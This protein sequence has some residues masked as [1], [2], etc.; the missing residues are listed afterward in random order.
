MFLA[1]CC[2]C[3]DS[4]SSPLVLQC[5]QSRQ[6]KGQLCGLIALAVLVASAAPFFSQG[7]FSALSSLACRLAAREPGCP[8]CGCEESR[9]K[10]VP[11][12]SSR[13]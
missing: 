13:E 4:G 9:A 3:S 11:P 5:N 6:D 8:A 12:S 2:C 1:A 10:H 7:L